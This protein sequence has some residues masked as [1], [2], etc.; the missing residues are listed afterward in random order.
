[1]TQLN[2]T[3]QN[4]PVE[5]LA[6]PSGRVLDGLSR[7]PEAER[8]PFREV[9]SSSEGREAP[10]L[11]G[12]TLLVPGPGEGWGIKV[13]EEA[14]EAVIWREVPSRDDD[15]R[16]VIPPP[17]LTEEE[18]SRANRERAIKRARVE[19]RRYAATNR[20]NRLVTFTYRHGVPCPDCTATR[21]RAE[22]RTCRLRVKR[23]WQAFG[24]R[25]RRAGHHL[26]WLRAVESHK[27]G[28]AHIHAAM[29]WG[30][31]WVDE[32]RTR[33]LAGLWG[34]GFADLSK[35]RE[36]GRAVGQREQARLVARYVVKYAVKSIENGDL[37]PG[38]HSYEVA[39]GFGPVAVR[40]RT[41]GRLDAVARAI[42]TMGGE[43]PRYQWESS[44]C[45]TW[46]GPPVTCL[47]W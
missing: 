2:P 21:P 18:R 34:E 20:T 43:V 35:G 12:R 14:G 8:Y 3:T 6:T 9:D 10:R 31:S 40:A 26:P 37:D 41:W 22:C 36:L 5:R 30:P 44:E 33:A 27:D 17:E 23:D 38:E 16:G 13:Y 1:M 7:S 19:A 42:E 4:Q 11:D 39:Q 28:S 47:S 15:E 24:R 29:A 25:L 45:L 32:R 46:T